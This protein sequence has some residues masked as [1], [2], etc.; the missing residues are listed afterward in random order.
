MASI[1]ISAPRQLVGSK[2]GSFFDGSSTGRARPRGRDRGLAHQSRLTRSP[3]DVHGD[4][5]PA[6]RRARKRLGVRTVLHLTGLSVARTRIVCRPVVRGR[7]GA[8]PLLPGVDRGHTARAGPAP[9][10]RIDLD[11]DL[12][13]A[14]VLIP[15]HPGNGDRAA[16]GATGHST[17]GCR[18]RRHADRRLLHPALGH[19]VRVEAA[20]RASPRCRRS[21]CRPTHIRSRPGTT[22]R[23]G[24]PCSTGSGCPSI[25]TASM[26][27]RPSI[28]AAVG[29][30]IVIPS[31]ERTRA[32]R[33][34]RAHRPRAGCRPAGA[35][36]TR[37]ADQVV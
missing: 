32:G 23:T 4:R 31:D 20:E 34:R 26:A 16:R 9:R 24:K 19:P 29:V 28:T 6:G 7:P 27:S 18:S 1:V 33:P 2:R 37:V 3:R 17:W 8:D 14:D 15:G 30:P 13:D 25:P 12:R 36:E 10:A 5:V 35:E 21:T 11:L 22:I